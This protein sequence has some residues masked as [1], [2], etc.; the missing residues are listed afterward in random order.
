MRQ[1]RTPEVHRNLPP[2]KVRGRAH[3]YLFSFPPIKPTWNQLELRVPFQG[4]DASLLVR[5]KRKTK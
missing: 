2:H 1:T 3:Q 4:T 5:F